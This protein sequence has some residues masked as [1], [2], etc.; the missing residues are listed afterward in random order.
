MRITA[1]LLRFRSNC[2]KQ[3]MKRSRL[4]TTEE[5]QESITTRIK[6]IENE[7]SQDMKIEDDKAKLHLG[8]NQ[9]G[10]LVCRERIQGN[11]PT[12]TSKQ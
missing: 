3:G 1:W 12:H 4:L 5:L 7:S 10:I 8:K 2:I 9:S 6:R 11:H